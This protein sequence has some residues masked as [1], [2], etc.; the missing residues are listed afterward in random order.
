MLVLLQEFNSIDKI[1]LFIK[2]NKINRIKVFVAAEAPAQVGLR[3]GGR[4]ELRAYGAAEPQVAI[5]ELRRHS[6]NIADKVIDFDM[7]AQAE[8]FPF[9]EAFAFFHNSPLS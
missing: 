3:T 9:R 4:K 2:H 8:Q 6:Q 1:Q 7:I 5:R